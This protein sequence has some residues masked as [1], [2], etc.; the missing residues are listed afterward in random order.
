MRI[1]VADDEARMQA[2]YRT[3]LEAAGHEVVGVRATGAS[4]S[5][6]AVVCRPTW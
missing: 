6:S 1:L 5:S 4:W 2:Y 3:V